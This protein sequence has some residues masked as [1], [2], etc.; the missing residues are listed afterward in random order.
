MGFE[1]T[2]LRMLAFRPDDRGR[3]PSSA[4]TRAHCSR[5]AGSC[6]RSRRRSRRRGRSAGRHRDSEHG[7]TAAD[8]R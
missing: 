1:M 7:R 2:L 4:G 8:E 5:S 3:N 6:A